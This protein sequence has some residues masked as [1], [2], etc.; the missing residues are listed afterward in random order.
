MNPIDYTNDLVNQCFALLPR[1]KP[2][3]QRLT[4]HRIIA[5]R[6]AHCR[7]RGL[8]ENTDAAFARALEMGCWGIELD[9]R[10]TADHVLVVNHDATLK[11]I[12]GVKRAIHDMTFAELRALVPEIPSLD[13]V[14]ARYARKLHLFIELKAPFHAEK[15][16]VESLLSLIPGQDYHLLSVDE[17]VFAPLTAFPRSI[18]LLVA[19]MSN[20]G[21]FCKLSLQKSYGGVMGHYVLLTN[22]RIKALHKAGQRVGVGFVDSRYSLYREVNRGLSWLFT[23]NVDAVIWDKPSLQA[24]RTD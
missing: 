8:V 13:E 20:T 7:K 18:Q 15:S 12:W 19:G 23:N 24:S 6:G 4:Q 1:K 11:R 17:P 5:H 21:R 9:I 2:D 16:L 3:L 10:T 14:V 22:A